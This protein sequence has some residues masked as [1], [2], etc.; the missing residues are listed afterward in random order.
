MTKTKRKNGPYNSEP[1]EITIAD[2][3]IFIGNLNK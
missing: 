1:C 3:T 2:F